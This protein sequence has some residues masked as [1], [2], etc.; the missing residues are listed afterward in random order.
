MLKEHEAIMV[1]FSFPAAASLAKDA[2]CFFSS[3]PLWWNDYLAEQKQETSLPTSPSSV[4]CHRLRCETYST[5]RRKVAAVSTWGRVLIL[6]PKSRR[7]RTAVC[8]AQPIHRLSQR[9]VVP[10]WQQRAH[11]PHASA[12]FCWHQTAVLVH[13]LEMTLDPFKL[14]NIFFCLPSLLLGFFSLF[15][16]EV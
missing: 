5:A 12:P 15:F 4:V 8:P 7:V 9:E 2:V 3:C 13:E 1:I 10:L 16:Y 14:E 6:L 11:K